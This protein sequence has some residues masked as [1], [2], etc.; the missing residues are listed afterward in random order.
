MFK[1][2]IVSAA[3]LL[4][5]GLLITGSVWAA[6]EKL[7][8][9]EKST[10][11]LVELSK[12]EENFSTFSDSC[13]VS[14]KSEQGVKLYIYI[15][16]EYKDEYHKL[17]VDD[18][19]VS[20]TV[21]VSGLFAKEIGLERDTLNKLLIYAE[22]ENNFQIMKRDITVK[23]LTLK[24]VLKNEVIKIDEFISKILSK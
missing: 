14:G 3:A 7:T 13:I 9:E 4:A 17:M 22:K 11:V 19:E 1:K 6:P 5:V 2:L 23:S 16:P 24:E 20:W 18:E 21:G 12:P 15:K 10:A 8:G